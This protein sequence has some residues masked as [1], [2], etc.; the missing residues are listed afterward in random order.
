M[1][2]HEASL[3]ALAAVGALLA[4]AAVG[5][6]VDHAPNPDLGQ[7]TEPVVDAGDA[8]VDGGGEVAD[9]AP[10]APDLEAPE[11][12]GA[13]SQGYDGGSDGDE[14]HGDGSGVGEAA[15]EAVADEVDPEPVPDVV[16]G[17]AEA[18]A[19][20]V[21]STRVQVLTTARC[22]QGRLTGV[23]V[24]YAPDSVAP[25]PG[26]LPWADGVRE[27]TWYWGVDNPWDEALEC[28]ASSE[29]ASVPGSPPAAVGGPATEARGA[30]GGE[31]PAPAGPGAAEAGP[32]EDEG[33]GGEPVDAPGDVRTAAYRSPPSG[34]LDPGAAALVLAALAVPAGAM[35]YRRISRDELLE[36]DT[37]RAIYDL[38][39][40]E[41]GMTA[42]EASERLD[43]HYRTARHHLGKLAEFGRVVGKR[44]QGRIRYFENH[45]RYG[46][47]Q[48]KVISCLESETKREVL[49]EIARSGA[50][51][52]GEVADRVDVAPSTASHH[53]G[54]L[55][56]EELVSGRRQGRSVL[57]R[58][59]DGV[60]PAL[61]D[62]APL[63]DD[64]DP[65]TG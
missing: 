58:L 8:D 32:D 57:Y 27:G 56:E 31:A 17:S 21:A 13:A 45:E 33:D 49:L 40:E 39:V 10:G 6:A 11:E 23:T 15:A 3:G 61:L 36:N 4:V 42:A 18:A 9:E 37:R 60:L 1:D 55:Q 44:I 65:R 50:I 29:S 20:E 2:P 63:R 26:A 62:L 28:E 52:S 47:I 41:P 16:G 7:A 54:D 5:G 24:A 59:E 22:H 43:V 25:V 46:R 19:G 48:K 35:L 64:E 34:F 30:G 14:G 53:L 51:R 12:T 38:V